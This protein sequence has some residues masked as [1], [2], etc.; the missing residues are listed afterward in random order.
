MGRRLGEHTATR[1]EHIGATLGGML[2]GFL[3]LDAHARE[4]SPTLDFLP[5]YHA[6][7]PL[8]ELK[9][10]GRP[11]FSADRTSRG[12][13]S[14]SLKDDQEEACMATLI[15]VLS[16]VHRSSDQWRVDITVQLLFAH[17][18]AARVLQT[19][20]PTQRS[21]VGQLRRWL[22]FVKVLAVATDDFRHE[23]RPSLYP[24]L[25]LPSL[26]ITSAADD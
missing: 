15:A 20:R 24:G 1:A 18:H 13:R 12:F 2:G 19:T 26:S 22:P 11:R 16:T 3:Q 4:L 6:V 9:L 21:R 8:R 17:T 14:S 7:A 25:T 23:V 5:V 10:H